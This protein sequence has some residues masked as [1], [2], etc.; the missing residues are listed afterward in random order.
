MERWHLGGTER[1]LSSQWEL[2][3]ILDGKGITEIEDALTIRGKDKYCKQK[4]FSA[5]FIHMNNRF[6]V[7]IQDLLCEGLRDNGYY[8]VLIGNHP[9][10]YN[11]M[12]IWYTKKLKLKEVHTYLYWLKF[13]KLLISI[14]LNTCIKL[15][16]HLKILVGI[17][18][19][20]QIP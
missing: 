14:N 18:L 4:C 5:F 15:T 13:I 2:E 16:L 7:Q 1:V 20:T 3:F 17:E 11:Y 8:V 12:S 19:E 6:I 9:T 10:S